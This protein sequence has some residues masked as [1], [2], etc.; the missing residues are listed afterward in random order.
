[1]CSVFIF[2]AK[3][4]ILCRNSSP[5][6]LGD[7]T[8][9]L[10]CLLALSSPSFFAA[11]QHAQE[12]KPGSILTKPQH[13]HYVQKLEFNESNNS[14]DGFGI[15]DRIL[16]SS[17]FNANQSVDVHRLFKCS[18]VQSKSTTPGRK[19][20]RIVNGKVEASPEPLKSS[21]PPKANLASRTTKENKGAQ[22]PP[23]KENKTMHLVPPIKLSLKRGLPPLTKPS[24]PLSSK[25]VMARN[26]EFKKTETTDRGAVVESVTSQPKVTLSRTASKAANKVAVAAA[27]PTPQQQPCKCKRS[28]CLKL[29]C[30]CFAAGLFCNALCKCADC[31]NNEATKAERQKAVEATL[32]RNPNA[33][34]PKFRRLDKSK[35]NVCHQKGCHC[36]K[37]GCLKKYCECYLNN[38]LCGENCKCVECKNFDGPALFLSLSS[39]EKAKAKQ[40]EKSARKKKQAKRKSS[41]KKQPAAKRKKTTRKGSGSA[42]SSPSSAAV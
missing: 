14:N 34:K 5:H 8:P 19:H 35:S 16:S 39:R 29:Y 22:S 33:F 2:I 24:I 26:E 20:L 25:T 30:D 10:S 37:S 18:K 11:R 27:C 12:A 7:A 36:K 38:A 28:K 9:S 41:V 23:K 13:L 40:L 32:E 17:T 4:L 42:T 3:R 15:K 1:M 6:V 21:L 31:L